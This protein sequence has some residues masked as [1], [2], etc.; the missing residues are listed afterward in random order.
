MRVL[1]QAL[2]KFYRSLIQGY[3]SSCM[4]NSGLEIGKLILRITYE[5]VVA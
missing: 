5:G 1:V 4:I 3:H 2:L